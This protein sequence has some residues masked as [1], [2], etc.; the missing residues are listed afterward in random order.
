MKQFWE[1]A[2]FAAINAAA[3]GA[4]AAGDSGANLKTVGVAAGASAIAGV[5]GF[6]LSHPIGQPAAPAV[7]TVAKAQSTVWGS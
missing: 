5:L 6:I 7:T 3:K 1:G 2:L 4:A